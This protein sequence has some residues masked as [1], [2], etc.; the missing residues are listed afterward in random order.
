MLSPAVAVKSH[1]GTLSGCAAF[2][3]PL[4]ARLHLLLHHAT[5]KTHRCR[6]LYCLGK[7]LKY[8][9]ERLRSTIK[10]II[11]KSTKRLV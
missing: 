7:K 1:G 3:R 6:D 9:S 5:M 8:G 2:K 11:R 10:T 4:Q